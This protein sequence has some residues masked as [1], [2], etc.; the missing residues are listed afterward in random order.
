MNER[1]INRDG[2]IA[3]EVRQIREKDRGIVCPT[4]GDGGTGVLANKEG[5][6]TK[7]VTE[8]LVRVR[9]IPYRQYVH[10]LRVSQRAAD[11]LPVSLPEDSVRHIRCLRRFCL[12]ALSAVRL[13]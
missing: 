13:L 5:I 10:N 3:E 9:S 2:A 7:I 11:C 8:L 1:H 12:P 4:F 6:T